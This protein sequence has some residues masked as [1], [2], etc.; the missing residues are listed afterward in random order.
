MEA[1]K[2]KLVEE[3]RDK[4][5]TNVKILNPMNRDL[6]IKEYHKA[7]FSFFASK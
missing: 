7:V 2:Q 1:T 5:I 4:G 6:L 3:I